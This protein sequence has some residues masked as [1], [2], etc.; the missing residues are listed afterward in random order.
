MYGEKLKKIRNSLN[1][2]QRGMA[3]AIGIKTRTYEAYE[4]NENEPPYSMLVV[5]CDKYNLN[6]N[7]F[8]ANKGDVFDK[9][10]PES[11][12]SQFDEEQFK[13]MFKKCMKEFKQGI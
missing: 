7:W 4:R 9:E 8:I 13:M 3:E 12:L 5:L 2:S 6:L 1:L 10:Q 11:N